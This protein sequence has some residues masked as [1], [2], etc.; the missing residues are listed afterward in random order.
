MILNRVWRGNQL[1]ILV[2][3]YFGLGL[4]AVVWGRWLWRGGKTAGRGA[5]R[6]DKTET[7]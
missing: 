5:G 6:Y 1:Y 4:A 7:A 2:L 3:L